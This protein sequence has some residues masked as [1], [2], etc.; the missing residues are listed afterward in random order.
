[1]GRGS[2]VGDVAPDSVSLSD[3][4]LVPKKPSIRGGLFT[5]TPSL[6]PAIEQGPQLFC[7]AWDFKLA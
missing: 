3:C 4:E 6:P 7:G 2:W 5:H 1:M